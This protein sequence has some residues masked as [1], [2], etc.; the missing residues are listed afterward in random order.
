AEFVATGLKT[1]EV[2]C[3]A[4]VADGR[5]HHAGLRVGGGNRNA[6]Y[7]RTRS[8]GYRSANRSTLSEC[9]DGSKKKADLPRGKKNSFHVPPDPADF[10]GSM[11]ISVGGCRGKTG[12]AVNSVFSV[13]LWLMTDH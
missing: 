9:I 1:R 3:S 13:S 11:T 12:K 8:I 10:G 5:G 6:R 4:F 2:V 7:Q